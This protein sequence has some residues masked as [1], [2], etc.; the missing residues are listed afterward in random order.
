[1]AIWA[2]ITVSW[3]RGSQTL[4]RFNKMNDYTSITIRETCKMS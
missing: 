3:Y 1:M 4:M 2:L